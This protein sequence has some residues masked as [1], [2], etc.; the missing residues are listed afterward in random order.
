M[1]R[2]L[3]M[4]W[5]WH[6]NPWTVL[7]QGLTLLPTPL[8]CHMYHVPCWLFPDS[9]WSR[10]R[11]TSRV[12]HLSVTFIDRSS[13]LLLSTGAGR[14]RWLIAAVAG[15]P[16]IVFCRRQR[17]AG[18]AGSEGWDS[19]HACYL[20]CVYRLSGES[21]RWSGPWVQWSAVEYWWP[22]P[23]THT[24]TEIY[25]TA[26][27]VSCLATLRCSVHCVYIGC[28]VKVIV[29]EDRDLTGQ[30]LSIDGPEG[31]VKLDRGNLNMFQMGCLCKVP[32]DWLDERT[33]DWQLALAPCVNGQTTPRQ[34]SQL[35][36]RHC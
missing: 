8:S 14:K 22:G 9:M 16:A 17:S 12:C 21:D 1:Y 10:V 15:A 36:H 13:G 30:L 5:L 32:R 20:L 34:R 18:N 25:S 24:H 27:C 26:P 33:I 28:Q 2:F 35:M 6:M 4:G 19:A 11:Q 3:P 29:G 23:H 7:L 31:V